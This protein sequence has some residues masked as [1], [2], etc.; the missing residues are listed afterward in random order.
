[1][2]TA[3]AVP[4]IG[5]GDRVVLFDGVCRLCNGWS[6]FIIQ[7]DTKR[8]LKLAPLQSPEGYDILSHFGMPTEHFNTM[9]YVENNRLYEKSTAFL[10]IIR[11]L[12]APWSWVGILHVIPRRFRDWAYDQIALNRYA[13][14]GKYDRCLLPKPDHRSRFLGNERA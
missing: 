3:K 6:T 14:F 5:N 10:K 7:H 2:S 1:M 12:P 9:V 8:A 13:L 11:H 4:H